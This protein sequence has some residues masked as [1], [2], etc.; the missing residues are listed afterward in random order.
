MLVDMKDYGTN[1]PNIFLIRNLDSRHSNAT[2][3]K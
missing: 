1:Y 3:P 2:D